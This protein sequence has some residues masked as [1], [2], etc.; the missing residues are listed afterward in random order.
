M[1]LKI[2][3]YQKLVFKGEFK[4]KVRLADMTLSNKPQ[5]IHKARKMFHNIEKVLTRKS[6]HIN[7]EP[8][9]NET[10]WSYDSTVQSIFLSKF[11]SCIKKCCTIHQP[12]II[13]KARKGLKKK[14]LLKSIKIFLSGEEKSKIENMVANNIKVSLKLKKAHRVQKKS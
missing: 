11:F 10:R 6:L 8:K 13:K 3:K 5:H 4:A 12:D 2:T 9:K 1:R 14:R 7:I